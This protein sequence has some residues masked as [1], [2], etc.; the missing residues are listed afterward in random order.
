MFVPNPQTDTVK[1]PVQL[2]CTTHCTNSYACIHKNTNRT[3]A[4]AL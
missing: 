2:R 3:S 1:A 4:A